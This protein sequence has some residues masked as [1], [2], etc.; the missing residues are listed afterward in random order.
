MLDI[1]ID[2]LVHICGAVYYAIAQKTGAFFKPFKR[3][4]KKQESNQTN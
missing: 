3:R 2:V 1:I 4:N